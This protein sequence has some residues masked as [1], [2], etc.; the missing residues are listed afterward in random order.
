M[1]IDFHPK[2]KYNCFNN[3]K[4]SPL[5]LEKGWLSLQAAERVGILS[6]SNKFPQ[7]SGNCTYCRT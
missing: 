3:K 1:P 4:K 7:G 2:K 5:H 6:A